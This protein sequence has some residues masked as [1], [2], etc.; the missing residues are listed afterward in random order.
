[1]KPRG[2]TVL[3]DE[4]NFRFDCHAGLE[5]FTK[6]CRDVTIFLTP[7]DIIR[8]KHA[9][10][11]TSGVFLRQYTLKLGGDSGLPAVLLK[12]Q[13]D[14]AK[15]CPFVTFSGC[16]VYPH[17]PWSCRIYPIQPE[18]NKVTEKANKSYFSVM[19]ISFCMGFF[20]D[21]VTTVKDWQAEQGIPVYH[22]MEKLFEKVV[23]HESLAA[24]EIVNKKIQD[25]FFMAAYDLD[26][27]RRFVFEST[28]LNRFEV[29]GDERERIKSDDVALY[30]FAMRWLQY[31]L[32]GQDALRLKPEAMAAKKN[33]LG[34]R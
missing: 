8:L 4:D 6:C 22:E 34:I 20:E 12:M 2:L 5:C 9:L 11:M 26:R 10:G 16:A 7:F 31:G 32:I 15:S 24:K 33:E 25:M 3:S 1:M 29:D 28:F 17:R 21:R 30:K 13:D 14:A 27:F 23:K 18:S 19:D